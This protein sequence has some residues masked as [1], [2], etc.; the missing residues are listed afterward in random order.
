MPHGLLDVKHSLVKFEKHRDGNTV[1]YFIQIN[2]VCNR[3]VFE[4]ETKRGK[5][6]EGDKDSDRGRQRERARRERSNKESNKKCPVL[7]VA[8]GKMGAMS[9]SAFI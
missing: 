4:R 3:V 2:R 7:I 5:E 6:R 1:V 8:A 9:V